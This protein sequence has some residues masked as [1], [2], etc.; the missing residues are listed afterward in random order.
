MTESVI[1][2]PVLKRLNIA[3]GLAAIEDLMETV[4]IELA[5]EVS[6]KQERQR[7][8]EAEKRVGSIPKK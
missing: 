7:R 3:T 4:E 8:K 5:K 2:Q 1:S 6:E